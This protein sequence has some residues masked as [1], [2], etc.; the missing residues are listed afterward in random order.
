MTKKNAPV[1]AAAFK[2]VIGEEALDMY[3]TLEWDADGD[4]NDLKKI[5]EKFAAR[6]VPQ[7]NEVFESYNFHKQFQQPGEDITSYT[8][9]LMKLAL[10]CNF[11]ETKDRQVR[12]RI[13]HGIRDNI[14]RQKLLEK[15]DL[16]LDSCI[17]IVTSYQ[18]VQE[19][20]Q[21]FQEE[22]ETAHAVSKFMNRKEQKLPSHWC[23]MW[24]GNFCSF[25]FMNLE[26]ACAVSSSSDRSIESTFENK[27][28]CKF[29]GGKHIFRKELCPA[30][31][32]VCHKCSRKEHFGSVCRTHKEV[33]HVQVED[34]QVVQLHHITEAMKQRQVFAT[35]KVNKK[36]RFLFSWTQG[37]Q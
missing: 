30:Y 18:V 19:R 3:E 20:V 14:V 8:T 2:N 29:C 5:I 33:S 37:Q 10:T 26:T 13:V 11:K 7:V 24:D 15:K 28:S 4:E 1:R 32:K 9:V 6:C 17:D 35:F 23:Q 25:L 22:E 12:D 16:T 27:R 36:L 21:E 34:V 31:G